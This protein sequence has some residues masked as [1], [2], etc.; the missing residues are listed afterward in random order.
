VPAAAPSRV[1]A[2]QLAEAVHRHSPVPLH[3][4]IRTALLQGIEHGWLPAGQQL[5]PER[6]L[7]EALGVSLAPVRQAMFELTKEGYLDRGRGRGTFVRDH[8]LVKKIQIVGGF[9]ASVE[10]QGPDLAIA[11]I[12]NEFRAAPAAVVQAL[13]LR[14]STA[15]HLRR[16]AR[17]DG[18]P[19]ALL[20]AWLPRTLAR[21][22]KQLDLAAGSLYQA[23][24]DVHGATM[25]TADNLIEVDRVAS[26]DADLL[27]VPAGSA[28]LRVIGIT[29]DQRNRPVE[30]SDVLYRPERFRVAIEST[31]RSASARKR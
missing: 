4:Q 10:G 28:V 29:R 15:W 24:A 22:V 21:G 3:H 20:T 31:A 2:D 7:A 13:A 26:A 17:L 8:K 5:P 16:L 23:L 6:D 27:G 11:V 19:A 30:Y 12:V 9:H 1:V 14:A 25:R 18:E